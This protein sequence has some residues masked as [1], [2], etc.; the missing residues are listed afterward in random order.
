MPSL[1]AYPPLTSTAEPTY[2]PGLFYSGGGLSCAALTPTSKNQFPELD[3]IAELLADKRSLATRRAYAASLSV[4][5]GATSPEA[6]DSA[7][8]GT[9]LASD[10]A[11]IAIRLHQWKRDMIAAGLAEATINLRLSAVRSLL[12]LAHRFGHSTTDGTNVVDGE[13]VI[14]YRDTRGYDLKTIRRLLALPGTD[15]LRGL[16]DTA[17]L[18]LLFTNG[19]RR[20]ELCTLTFGDY[21][22]DQGRILIKGKGRGTQREPLDLCQEAQ[23]ALNDYLVAAGHTSP[24]ELLLRSFQHQRLAEPAGLT[25]N[26][27][28]KVCVAYGNM[29]GIHLNP[30][31]IRHSAITLIL[32]ATNGNLREA[33]EFARHADP[34]TTMRYDDNRRGNQGKLSRVLGG[35]VG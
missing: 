3:L 25:D 6:I 22:P 15:T 8:V 18:W 27:L 24:T 21:E 17:M 10:Q 33:Q 19:L 30:H 4:F 23:T 20:S 2:P 13:Q 34:R 14:S 29:I 35:L 12:K 32:D 28:W 16:R 31:K 9:F 1:P 5:F 26:G 7:Q 11:T